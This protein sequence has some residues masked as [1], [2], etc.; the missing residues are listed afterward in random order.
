MGIDVAVV[1]PNGFQLCVSFGQNL[2]ILSI[3]L[4]KRIVFHLFQFLASSITCKFSSAIWLTP[5]LTIIDFLLAVCLFAAVVSATDG[6]FELSCEF[7]SGTFITRER[8]I[9]LLLSMRFTDKNFVTSGDN[10]LRVY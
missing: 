2:K 6:V 10:L 9:L 3:T 4:A 1:A 7:V 5:T 8:S